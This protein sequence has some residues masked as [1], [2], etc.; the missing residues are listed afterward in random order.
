MTQQVDP[1]LPLKTA[2]DTAAKVVADAAETAKGVI[3]QA[4]QVASDLAAQIK[5][6]NEQTTISLTKAL[7]DVFGEHTKSQ[8]FI[9]VTRIPLICKSI[10]D[11]SEQLKE[12]KQTLKSLDGKYVTH[13][14][15]KPIS[16]IVWGAVK[17]IGTAVLLAVLGL[18]LIKQ[19]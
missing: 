8:R 14:E 5:V 3:D 15:F 4:T 12:I 19:I 11:T 13:E 18:V 16:A 6:E 10:F 2:S 9:D 7:R 17:V 1:T